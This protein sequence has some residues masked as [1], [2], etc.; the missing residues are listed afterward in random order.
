MHQHLTLEDFVQVSAEKEELQ[1]M[2]S[3]YRLVILAGKRANQLSKPETRPL[4]GARSRKPVMIALQEVL[5][6][7]VWYRLG[8]EEEE[9]YDLG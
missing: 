9:E 4:V 8:E 1:P 7:K 6:G 2:D 3:L 5:E